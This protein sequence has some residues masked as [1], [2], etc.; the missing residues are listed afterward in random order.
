MGNIRVLLYSP[1]L[2]YVNR[3]LEVFTRELYETLSRTAGLS[4]TLLQGGGAAV[5]GA[6]RVP[7][8]RRDAPAYDLPFLRRLKKYGYRIECVVFGLSLIVEQCMRPYDIVHFSEAVP[9]NMLYRLRRMM[10][11]RFKLLFSNGGPV[12]PEHFRRYDH[13][14]V[15][16]P[17]QKE[18][19]IAWGYPEERLHLLPYGVDCDKFSPDVFAGEKKRL[20]R[21]RM[22]PEDRTVILSVGS[23]QSRLKRMDHLIREFARLDPGKFFLW[24]V[25]AEDA[26]SAEID[27]LA[28]ALLDP[29]SYRSDSFAYN[30]MPSVYASADHFV[31]CSLR[32]GFGRAY[33]EAMASGLPVIGHRN[34]D[35]EWILGKDNRGLV[36]MDGAG[37]LKEV[38][39]YFEENS[40]ERARQGDANRSR[41]QAM[42][43]RRVLCRGYEDMYGKIVGKDGA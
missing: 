14:Q 10:R 25:G 1:G 6:R 32:E 39:E 34:R 18:E 13:V 9:A 23:R 28:G 15:L 16:T 2:G 20:R 4:V 36:S 22:L 30:E 27:A 19:A 26:E 42:F 12:S 29:G 24:M 5:A 41:T 38:I 37:W 40:E 31:L 11:G 7:A 17:A 43:D 21:D 33:L 3:G 35:T 8:P